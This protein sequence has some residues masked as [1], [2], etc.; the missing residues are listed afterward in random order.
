MNAHLLTWDAPFADPGTA[1]AH[2]R[3]YCRMFQMPIEPWVWE[4][5]PCEFLSK[6]DWFARKYAPEFGPEQNLGSADLLAPSTSCVTWFPSAA[7]MPR[8]VKNERFTIEDCG[9]PDCA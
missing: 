7:E 1:D 8:V 4:K 2:V 3:D 9:I 6:N 5:V